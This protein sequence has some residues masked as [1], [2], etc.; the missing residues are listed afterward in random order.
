MLDTFWLGHIDSSCETMIS[1]G[2][3]KGN[4]DLV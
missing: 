3:E 1:L 2:L 4:W